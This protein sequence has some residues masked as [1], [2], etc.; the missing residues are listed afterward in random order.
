MPPDALIRLLHATYVAPHEGVTDA[1]LL[2]RCAA[3]KD[4]ATF[5]LLIRRHADMVWQVWCW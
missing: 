2:G 3:G 4:D 5:E 1:E